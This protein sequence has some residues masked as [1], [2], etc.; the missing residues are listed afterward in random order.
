MKPSFLV[1]RCK[2]P[3][4]PEACPLCPTPTLSWQTIYSLQVSEQ[5]L[6]GPRAQSDPGVSG[7][8]K[9]RCVSWASQVQPD[10]QHPGTVSASVSSRGCRA[11]RGHRPL[12]Q[13]T[14]HPLVSF[15]GRA[16]SLPWVCV[17]LP[18]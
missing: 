17:D 1:S 2:T 14:R 15:L 5:T 12:A 10:A 18:C 16:S 4:G 9:C 13:A 8:S 6:M 11:Q 3:G 7:V